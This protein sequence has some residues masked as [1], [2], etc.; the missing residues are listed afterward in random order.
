MIT[1]EDLNSA[2]NNSFSKDQEKKKISMDEI[3][4]AIASSFTDNPA[5][6][7]QIFQT[8]QLKRTPTKTYGVGGEPEVKGEDILAKEPGQTASFMEGPDGKP[9]EVRRAEGID[10]LG[11]V[12]KEPISP[13]GLTLEAR[14][15]RI[16][17]LERERSRVVSDQFQSGFDF[18]RPQA[19]GE[20]KFK[21]IQELKKN[22]SIEEARYKEWLNRLVTQKPGQSV[23]FFTTGEQDMRGVSAD[24]KETIPIKT[25]VQQAYDIARKNREFVD[26]IIGNDK[27]L[28]YAEKTLRVQRP[29][30]AKTL[31]G[32]EFAFPETLD[33]KNNWINSLRANPKIR[34]EAEKWAMTTPEVMEQIG[35]VFRA[36]W[37]SYAQ[38][39]GSAPVGA[40]GGV[41]KSMGLEGFGAELADT[42]IETAEYADTARARGSEV[43][44]IGGVSQFA[45][46]V[47]GG[48][49]SSLS[50]LAT[51]LIGKSVGA[52]AGL[53]KGTRLANVLGKTGIATTS[54][55]NEFW[56]AY[57]EAR[58]SGATDEQ[59]TTSAYLTGITNGSIELVS[60]LNKMLDRLTPKSKSRLINATTA[61]VEAILEGTEEALFNEMPQ[62]IASNI[63]KKYVYEPNQDVFEGVAQSGEVGGAA[64]LITSLLTS[65]V[66]AR[67][68]K[69]ARKKGDETSKKNQIETEADKAARELVPDKEAQAG[70]DMVRV[71]N[72]IDETKKSIADDELAIQSFEEGTPD[73]QQLKLSINE[74]KNNLA[75]L[76]EEFT[77]L[78][79]L[80]PQDK[81]EEQK[82]AGDQ[83][84]KEELNARI[85]SLNQEFAQLD[86][87]DTEGQKRINQELS[88]AK[89]ELAKL[90]AIESGVEPMG[91]TPTQPTGEGKFF[92][93]AEA[94]TRTQNNIKTVFSSILTNPQS[95]KIKQSIKNAVTAATNFLAGSGAQIVTIEEYE[96][97]SGRKLQRQTSYRA[98]Y[99]NGNLYLILPDVNALAEQA[100]AEEGRRPGQRARVDQMAREAA[101]RIEEEVI[102][103]SVL[104]GLKDEY[105]LLKNPKQNEQ[106][107]IQD[108]IGKIVS[109]VQRTNP[110][111]IPATV[112]VYLGDPQ[113]KLTTYE[114]GMEFL[115]I[116]SQRMRTGQITEDLQDLQNAEQ[117]AFS[118]Q[119]KSVIQKFKNAILN[120]LKDIRTSIVRYL[121]PSTS[122]PEVRRMLDMVNQELDKYGIARGEANY[123]FKDYTKPAEKKVPTQ[124]PAAVAPTGEQPVVTPTVSVPITEVEQQQIAAP[125]EEAPAPKPVEG[126]TPSPAT[127]QQ[128]TK[129]GK[130]IDPELTN[131]VGKM[132]GLR[133]EGGLTLDE[134]FVYRNV[135]GNEVISI[136]QEGFMITDPSLIGKKKK[137]RGQT[138][139]KMFSEF[140]PEIPN[141]AYGKNNTIIRV[142]KENV[143]LGEK[144]KAV[145]ESDV[146]VFTYDGS[147]WVAQTPAEFAKARGVDTGVSTDTATT[148]VAEPAPKVSIDTTP[149]EEAPV[150]PAVTEEAP[151]PTEAVTPTPAAPAVSE[152]IT[153]ETPATGEL[154]SESR[155]TPREWLQGNT[156]GVIGD[157]VD[158][159]N[160]LPSA[161]SKPYESKLKQKGR[162]FGERILSPLSGPDLYT[163]SVSQAGLKGIE[164]IMMENPNQ[165]IFT[166]GEN[167]ANKE[168]VTNEEASVAVVMSQL[169]PDFI[170]SIKQSRNLSPE[171]RADL[172]RRGRELE[173]SIQ[174]AVS[175]WGASAPKTL[176][177]FRELRQFSSAGGTIAKYKSDIVAGMGKLHEKLG[178]TL[179]YL[180]VA[181]REDR[182]KALNTVW[183]ARNVYR[184]AASLVKTASLNPEKAKRD[185]RKYIGKRK[186]SNRM[187]EVILEFASRQFEKGEKKHAD[188]MIKQTAEYIMSIGMNRAELSID[189]MEKFMHRAFMTAAKSEAMDQAYAKNPKLK[190][191]S[192]APGRNWELM[193]AIIGNDKAFGAFI[194]SLE[195][196][197][198]GKYRN[199][200]EFENDFG[201]LFSKLKSREFSDSLLQKAI[202]DTASAIGYKYRELI[203]YLAEQRDVNQS[204]V[205]QYM[206]QQLAP[207]GIS[208]EQIDSFIQQVDAVLEEETNKALKDS[209]AFRTSPDETKAPRTTR[210]MGEKIKE[211]AQSTGFEFVRGLQGIAKLSESDEG[212]FKDALIERIII[213]AGVAEK[214]AVEFADFLLE[215][216]NNAV[217]KQRSEN[218]INAIARVLKK[219]GEF[220]VKGV[221]KDSFLQGIIKKANSGELDSLLVYETLR[222]QGKL[223]KSFPKYSPEFVNQL[224]K[225]G[226]M[227]SKLPQG[228]VR[229]IE[230]QKIG[231]AMAQQTPFTLDNLFSTYWYWSLLSQVAT[232]AINISSGTANLFTN[233]FIWAAQTKGK[234][235][236]PQAQ[237]FFHAVNGT[238]ASA[239]NAFMYVMETGLNPGGVVDERRATY[240]NTGL[241]EAVTPDNIN[242][243]I[244]NF[245]TFGDGRISFIPKSVSKLISVASPRGFMRLMRATDYFLREAAYE[246]KM[247]QAGAAPFSPTQFQLALK[248]ASTELAPIKGDPNTKQREIL[249]RAHEINR[250]Q[251]LPSEK[252]RGEVLQYALETTFQ[253]EPMGIMGDIAG[254][255]NKILATRKGAKFFVPFTNTVANVTNELLNYTPIF[256]DLRR[257]AEIKKEKLKG[258]DVILGRE[259]KAQELL[260]KSMLGWAA[261]IV[262]LL[263]QMLQSGDEEDEDKRPFIQLYSK[264]PR[265]E[266]QN[267]I[268]KQNGGIPFSVRVGKTYFSLLTTPLVIPL[269]MAADIS[270]EIQDIRRSGLEGKD[271][272][273][274]A[275]RLLI[276]PLALGFAATMSQSFLT[277]LSDLAEL[278]DSKTPSQDAVKIFKQIA[279]RMIVP[280]QLRDI[281]KL[282][283]DDRKEATNWIGSVINEFP[284]LDQLLLPDAVGY[285]GDKLKYPSA[286]I[287]D[288]PVRRLASL[289]GRIV[290]SETTDEAMNFIMAN[291]LTPPP[292]E[293]SFEWGGNVKMTKPEQRDFMRLAGPMMKE[294]ILDN[295]EDIISTIEEYGLEVG[296]NML[297]K[298]ISDARGRA[299]DEMIN[300]GAYKVEERKEERQ[301]RMQSI[302]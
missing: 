280:G 208:N 222:E 20:D 181:L 62:Q 260:Y 5:D 210:L 80:A 2:I 155:V 99:N 200:T 230:E 169:L 244:Y 92:W 137:P 64:G 84:Q 63:F 104:K 8:M 245:I 86:E 300:S 143:P 11:R 271:A 9:V 236:I 291:K 268:W 298:V 89:N 46:D 106:E 276:A 213:E 290:S 131:S 33:A 215:N 299:K 56:G 17:Q 211:T 293:S 281:N 282:T 113:G 149:V 59:A 117:E 13:D 3:D 172:V 193:Q 49:G 50:F 204:N 162:K 184:R 301:Q 216:I 289:F 207:L 264:G 302:R 105:S 69:L 237:A 272:G 253:Q 277:G 130:L 121:K 252:M 226:D 233:N 240:L 188:M 93:D 180:A 146:E 177:A 112:R 199:R 159:F 202:K 241:L 247:I 239:V 138:T 229:A 164:K 132:V 224:R 107:Y 83:A 231:R 186:P 225:W 53:E 166:I 201:D 75:K 65:A 19:V 78:S 81:Q 73:H 7:E 48:V 250:E 179:K 102:H 21:E 70:A 221:R 101:K 212:S 96:N 189:N 55:L 283:S 109:E 158:A 183:E 249:I 133:T 94:K 144:G 227:I 103:L 88:V 275:T 248:Q 34:L 153:E 4:Y 108:R 195:E 258:S 141:A 243:F 37:D 178:E 45:K 135:S 120:A 170:S 150:T 220:G 116:V 157:L 82:P 197:I 128:T 91:T 28:A 142:R 296:Q 40:I 287:E 191:R 15:T 140:N 192:K 284:V 124:K 97:I 10:I 26:G 273:E 87:N 32:E 25:R 242:K 41:L 196:Q 6:R 68:A 123:E 36:T 223:P 262:P 24:K 173:A 71:S 43:R 54:G 47:A 126:S 167:L 190:K 27:F 66:G 295:R 203:G 294:D 38:G 182:R 263:I 95:E 139:Q 76:E 58:N 234:S 16:Q 279:A 100:Q 265:D 136:A 255:A 125:V 115:R 286:V 174:N 176:V 148:P 52:I 119:D 235:L 238:N 147:K 14:K 67:R 35:D 257:R 217:E 278:A 51:G 206:R 122:T 90:E 269:G 1:L 77:Q 232:P 288:G 29:E 171:D 214:D 110:D 152:T 185:I 187:Q 161:K 218:S 156:Q 219:A 205:K 42:L 30:Q 151:A 98:T 22:Q 145:R 134:G 39:V 274:L 297:N 228:Q 74:K 127:N 251:R 118:D 114:K 266:R 209:L 60:P 292:W 163:Q 129:T 85:E 111:A 154:T 18:S 261:L 72:K 246:T 256:S 79:K 198:S 267:K 270:E 168:A 254:L 194:N 175:R 165:D 57:Q 23:S 12:I 259:D 285:F 44:K 61:G 160:S 31:F